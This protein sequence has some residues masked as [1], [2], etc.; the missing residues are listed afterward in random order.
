MDGDPGLGVVVGGGR[1]EAGQRVP[2]K[3]AVWG[4]TKQKEEPGRRWPRMG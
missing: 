3:E 1:R 4:K 2:G